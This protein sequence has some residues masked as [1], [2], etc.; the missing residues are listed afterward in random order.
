MPFLSELPD[1]PLNLTLLNDTS[2][3]PLAE[4]PTGLFELPTGSLGLVLVLLV[5]TMAASTV[6]SYCYLP[7]RWQQLVPGQEA[8]PWRGAA[9]PVVLSSTLALLL[10]SVPFGNALWVAGDHGSGQVLGWL[11][12]VLLLVALLLSG[13]L[14]WEVMEDP[15]TTTIICKPAPDDEGKEY[16]FEYIGC[17]VCKKSLGKSYFFSCATCTQ[18][19]VNCTVSFEMCRQCVRNHDAT[20]VALHW[21]QNKCVGQVDYEA[22][23]EV[24]SE[25]SA[26][27][28]ANIAR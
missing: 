8:K 28:M 2:L 9:A 20:H 11:Q 6:V 24:A 1:L 17:M 7:D 14:A 27:L 21:Q 19:K 13:L 26:T 4:S 25:E 22:M 10:L 15:D 3:L 12:L 23:A 16:P 18:K 5:G